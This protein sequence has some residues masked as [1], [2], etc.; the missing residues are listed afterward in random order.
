MIVAIGLNDEI[1]RG[2]D[3]IW[4]IS[5]DLRRFK[6][7]TSGHPV[8]MGRKTWE[9]LSKKPLPGR[10]NIVLTRQKD[11]VAEGAEVV[12]SLEEAL[13]ITSGNDPFVIG[14][15]ELYKA[16]WPQVTD[17]FLTKIHDTCSE[18]D[19]FLKLDLEPGWTLIEKSPLWATADDL[20]FQYLTY[21]RNPDESRNNK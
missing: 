9:S 12:D 7:L 17:L 21:R 16:A 4:K 14:G 11:Y 10:R 2:G 8:I 19:A 5:H 18:A 3:L 20:S 6:A 13:K 1:G 15:A